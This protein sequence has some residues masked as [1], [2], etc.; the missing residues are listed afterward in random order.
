MR[1]HA[2]VIVYHRVSRRFNNT[3]AQLAQQHKSLTFKETPITLYTTVA[4]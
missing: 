1:S 4:E 2:D 3:V